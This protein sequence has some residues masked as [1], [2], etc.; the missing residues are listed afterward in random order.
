MHMHT[1]EQAPAVSLGCLPESVD[2]NDQRM[3]LSAMHGNERSRL[4]RLG[5]LEQNERIFG[6]ICEIGRAG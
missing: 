2:E 1:H 6:L 3:A 4:R 5:E